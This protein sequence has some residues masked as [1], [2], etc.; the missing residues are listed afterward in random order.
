MKK[1][2][3][4]L[5]VLVAI[6]FAATSCFGPIGGEVTFKESD[7]LGLWLEENTEAYVRF[8]AEKDA[9]S[10]YKYGCEWDEAEGVFEEDLQPYGNGWFK[11]KLVQADLT[12]IH[13]MDNGG[14]DIPRVYTVLELTDDLLIY[15]D[16]YKRKHRLIKFVTILD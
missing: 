13:L 14:A 2:S 15:E 16:D 4:I 10:E 11:Y 8:T 12:Q 5:L 1:N 6:A 7:L 3:I 9:T